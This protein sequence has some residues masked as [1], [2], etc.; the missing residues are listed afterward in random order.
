MDKIVYCKSALLSDLSLSRDNSI[1]KIYS[2][3]EPLCSVEGP[4]HLV[5]ETVQVEGWVHLVGETVQPK[6]VIPS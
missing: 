1:L 5:G 2:G 6:G 4:V 3:M